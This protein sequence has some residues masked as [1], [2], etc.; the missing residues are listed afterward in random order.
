MGVV[1][2]QPV[3]ATGGGDGTVRLWDPIERAAL[4]EPLTG[5]TGGVTWGAWGRVDGQPVLA[6][7]GSDGTVRLWD[8]I[9][10]AALGEPLT[11]HTGA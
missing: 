6:T 11:G 5:H 3:L 1:D 7:G 2:G 10:R 4:G 9:E 8:P